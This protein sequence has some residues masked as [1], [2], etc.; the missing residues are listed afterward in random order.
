MT[1]STKYQSHIDGLRGI[2]VLS[3]IFFHFGQTTFGGGF[4][5]VDVFFVI[6]GFLITRLILE[7]IDDT[8]GFDFK[9][10][11]IRRMRRLFPA[12]LATL[13]V[14]LVFAIVLFSPERFQEFG[15]SFAAAALSVSNIL[16][17][18]ES[19]YFDA[20]SHLKPL[21]HTWSLSVEEQFYLF[22]PALLWII[23]QK[24]KCYLRAYMLG[25]IGIISL[26]LNHI[27]VVGNFDAE[28]A[29]T[30]FYL[31]P[32]RIFELALGAMAIFVVP[33][34]ASR[35]WL[36]EFGMMLGLAL[37]AYS[38]FTFTDKLVFP[39]YYALVPCIGGFLVILSSDSR[40]F[41]AILTNPVAVGIG[42]I[43]YSMY[44]VHWP[45]LVFYEYYRFEPLG[46]VEYIVLFLVTLLLSLVMY[47][48]VEKPFRKR[49]P[50][51]SHSAPQK[52]FVVSN[53]SL[54]AVAGLVGL[55]IGISSG[56]EWR[57]PNTLSATDISDG[58]S[59]RYN[60]IR[61]GCNLNRL[62]NKHF[63]DMDRPLQILVIGNSHETDGYNAFKH[64]YGSDKAVN[65]IYFGS[66]NKCNMQ[67]NESGPF[68]QVSNRNCDTRFE[69]LN[70]VEFI[71]SLDGLVFSS[72]FPFRID[73]KTTWRILAHL[74]RI[75]EKLS[76]VVMSGYLNTHRDCSEL[77][78][79]YLTFDICRD[80]KFVQ[81][82]PFN[83]RELSKIGE[84]SDLEYLYIDKT[85]LLCPGGTLDACAVEAN[86]EPAFYD[87][88]HLSLGFAT[89][90]G[91]RIIDIYGS[92]LNSIGLTLP[93]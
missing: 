12:L 42:L 37:I 16:F 58:K 40:I 46:G 32:F 87:K 71:S 53:V 24:T 50:T 10:F 79:R 33:L 52:I 17:W 84:S 88:H 92:E 70:N 6:S 47:F 20:D 83:E 8:G 63:C 5:G 15:R 14:S 74:K 76:L 55:Q 72:N 69:M 62:D 85:R 89:Y 73:K 56:W 66:L 31:T 68:S 35:R 64:V 13:V 4:V 43:S 1:A 29:S 90:L 81:N 18:T 86:G 22:W 26:T 38:V 93:D 19:G 78:N 44:L 65:L 91:E 9:R 82:N 28:Y 80:S 45:V 27:W 30:I 39:Y 75:N 67:F 21:L 2:S 51:R 59:R 61:Q 49:S 7:E 57:Q 77:I 11:Y 23:T 54:M 60:L 48:F 34:F 25:A 41:G 36:H 3:V